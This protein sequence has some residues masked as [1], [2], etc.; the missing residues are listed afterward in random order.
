MQLIPIAQKSRNLKNLINRNIHTQA[1]YLFKLYT[2]QRT[3]SHI[4]PHVMMSP[5]V[6]TYFDTSLKYGSFFFF[7]VFI[8]KW[9]NISQNNPSGSYS[10][11]PSPAH[12]QAQ[13]SSS[14]NVSF[15]LLH[16]RQ[17]P[18]HNHTLISPPS[19]GPKTTSSGSPWYLL[20]FT[21]ALKSKVLS[22]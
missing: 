12:T 19:N 16:Q 2:K 17:E 13:Q 4:T 18:N 9:P 10:S 14:S 7:L 3:V 6:S 15:I 21:P 1:M 8:A 11:Q 5:F 22:H 20:F